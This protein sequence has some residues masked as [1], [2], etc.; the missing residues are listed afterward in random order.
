MK[1]KILDCFNEHF[2]ASG[3]LFE[4]LNTQH[5]C[6][7]TVETV[8]LDPSCQSFSFSPITVSDV[9]DVKQRQLLKFKMTLLNLQIT[10]NIV[11]PFLLTSLRH[12]IQ[13]TTQCLS[14]DCVGLDFLNKL[15]AGLIII[16]QTELSVYRRRATPLAISK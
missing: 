5:E 16:L 12:L 4:S 7:S 15:S 14:T 13:W 6:S 11:Q 9:N 2:I 10:S 3:F 8:G 1:T